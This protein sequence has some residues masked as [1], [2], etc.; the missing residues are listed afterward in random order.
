MAFANTKDALEWMELWRIGSNEEQLNVAG[1]RL[2]FR[3]F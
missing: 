1:S 2:H 3:G